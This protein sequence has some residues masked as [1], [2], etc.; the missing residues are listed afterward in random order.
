MLVASPA[1]ERLKLYEED[2]APLVAQGR[3]GSAGAP[4]GYLARTW[5][6]LALARVRALPFQMARQTR[7]EPAA[8]R[9]RRSNPSLGLGH[10]TS[11]SRQPTGS[12]RTPTASPVVPRSSQL[13][14]TQLK[15][16]P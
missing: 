8:R 9:D 6:R 7:H 12:H 11:A 2:F 10:R 16:P 14:A 4:A 3:K 13:S 15:N 1:L 5:M